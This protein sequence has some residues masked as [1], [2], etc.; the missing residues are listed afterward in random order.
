MSEPLWAE[1][2]PA[3]SHLP[4]F[5]LEAGDVLRVEDLAGQQAADVVLAPLDDPRDWLSCIYTQLLNRTTRITAGHVLYSKRA[6]PLAAVVADTAGV[7]WF[8][9]GCCSAE[10][11]AFRYGAAPGG[12]CRENLVLSLAGR[13]AGAMDL[14]L[15]A[16]ASLFMNIA[17]AG[18]GGMEIVAPTSGPGDHVDLRAER[19]LLVA[20]SACPQERNPCNGFEPSAVGLSTWRY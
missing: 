15:D 20:V 17:V 3:R 14:E 10:T 5:V 12:S 1:I 7:H 4:A 18:D 9:G 6:R 11:N 19:D 13:I 16:C 8:G 2:V